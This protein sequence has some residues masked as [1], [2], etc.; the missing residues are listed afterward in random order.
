MSQLFQ[1]AGTVYGSGA[2]PGIV[3]R[4][5]QKRCKYCDDRDHNYEYLLNMYYGVIL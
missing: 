5:K 4:R 1:I 2:H 3:Q